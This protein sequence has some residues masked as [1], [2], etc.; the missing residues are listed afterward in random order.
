[1]K[2]LAFL[3]LIGCCVPLCPITALAIGAWVDAVPFGGVELGPGEDRAALD[4]RLDAIARETA[5]GPFVVTRAKWAAAV[6]DNV[7]LAVNTNDLFVHWHP[8]TSLL[9]RRFQR[10]LKDFAASAPERAEVGAWMARQGAFCAR[11]DVSHTCPDWRSILTL[12]P[13]GLAERARA[14]LKVATDADARVFLSSVITVYEAL[15]RECLRWADLAASK[16]MVVVAAVLRENAAHPPRTFREALQWA[17]VYD[18]AQEAEGED[19]RSQGLFDRLFIDY[20]RADLAAG[21][22]TRESAK[23]LLAD[24]F[25]RFWSQNHP[26]NKNVA[27]GGYDAQGQ[28][29]WNELT[30]LVIEVFYAR[31]RINPKLTYRFGSRTPSAQLEKVTR[32]LAAGRT[33]IVFA[34]D[35]VLVETFRRCGKESADIP[36]YVLVGCY[37]PA[38]GGRE[39]ISSMAAE[40][41][42]VKSIETTFA[43][44]ELPATYAAFE[45]RYFEELG[46]NIEA[47]LATTRLAEEHWPNL[48]PSP[49]FSGSMPDCI[50]SGRDISSGGCRYNQSGVVCLGLATAVDS[51]AAVR[52]LVDETKTVTMASLREALK[53][54]W[55]G[56]DELRLRARR[57][58]PKWGCND[59]RADEIGQRI[60]KFATNLIHA[61]RNGH[62]GTF[63]AGFW[64]INRDISFGSKTGATPDGRRKGESL[65]RNN[66]ASDGC[67]REGT[68]ALMLSNLKLDLAACPDGHI[69]DALLPLSMARSPNAAANLAAMIAGY[70]R[71]G[72]QCLHLNCFDSSLLREATAHPERYPD[73]Q[74]RVCGWNARWNDLPDVEKRRFI[75]AVEAQEEQ[76]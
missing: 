65:S 24:W 67:G 27:I 13:K 36:E 22:E 46:R 19:V 7:R 26:N 32:C 16:G 10:R 68:T 15:A 17:L 30:E 28:P 2:I 70:F 23:R 76:R 45:A 21:R 44:S 11:V 73:L 40:V 50:A 8:D 61:Q 47:A 56:A 20:Y 4:L 58:A 41:S 54:N 69:L 38:I 34:N 31:N 71:Q 39:V 60:Q 72:G 43:S 48:N 37:E 9:G 12:G 52:Y 35:D 1:M 5:T 62:G 3:R 75:A 42:L 57:L 18:R 59:N 74:V 14:Q 33:S 66:S 64:S 55:K 63:E 6:Y 25:D 51:L 29:V 53:A 49:L